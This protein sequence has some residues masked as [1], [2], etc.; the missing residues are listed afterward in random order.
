MSTSQ[1]KKQTGL[2]NVIW[3]ST[4]SN[5]IHPWK[6][7]VQRTTARWKKSPSTAE[8]KKEKK[9]REITRWANK[10]AGSSR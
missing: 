2:L 9:K 4:A 10:N 8:E 5:E 1:N 3:Q 6:Q 7:I